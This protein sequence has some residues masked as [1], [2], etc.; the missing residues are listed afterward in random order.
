MAPPIGNLVS[1]TFYGG[2]LHNGARAI[3]DLYQ[4]APDA[5]RSPVTWLDTSPLGGRA[6]HQS[7]RGVSIYNRC[8]AEQVIEV[9]KQISSSGP[10][11]ASLCELK[12]KEDALVGVIC[13]YAEQ[14]RL[15]R[16]KFN[17]EIWTEG[18]KELVK[19]DTVDSYQGKENRI[20]ILSLT[21]SD[22]A[23]TP[24]F[25]RTPNRINVAMSRAMD[26]LLIIGNG[27]MW[28][29]HNKDKPLGQVVSY[30]SGM[31]ERAGY[32][33]VPALMKR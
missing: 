1:T 28:S 12:D 8:E 31:G 23:R 33:F 7:D 22:K 27:D 16:Q 17:Q 18:F 6:Y 29:N 14:K 21:R 11:L 5:L 24:G 30:M 32:R 20:I 3:P 2:K 15:I 26:R 25:L 13:M 9:L 19:I 10:F 4:N